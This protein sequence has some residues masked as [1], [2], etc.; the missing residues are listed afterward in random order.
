[1]VTEIKLGTCSVC[2]GSTRRPV[3]EETRKYI[4]HNAR[5]N[6]WSIAGYE[7][8]G[9]GPF[10][11]GQGYEGGTL[12]CTNCGGQTMS[13]KATGQVRLR[14]DGTPCKHEYKLRDGSNPGRGWYRY[15]C[16][17]CGDQYD[18]DSGD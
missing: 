16:R 6:H 10:V 1:M 18:L 2:L 3:P 14:P 17:H 7:P 5:W 13:L 12:P 11:D 9:P 8:A 15:E 4:K